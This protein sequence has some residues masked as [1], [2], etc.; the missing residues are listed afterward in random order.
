MTDS[1]LDPALTARFDVASKVEPPMDD[2]TPI[3][4]IALDVGG[5]KCAG[6]V[7]AVERQ[8]DVTGVVSASV[9]LVT[10]MA[11]VQYRSGSLDPQTLVQ[12][13]TEAGFP[14]QIRTT[15]ALSIEEI[16]ATEERQY[17]AA[18]DRRQQLVTA[19]VL[20]VL[21][22]IG[23]AEMLGLPSL[24]I[25]S[26]IWFHYGLATLSLLFPGR[27]IL[28]DGWRGLTHGTP[29]MNTL[30]GLGVTTA[31]VASSV[32][33]HVP[34]LGWDC[35]F[36]EP[37]MLLGFILLGRALER[38]ARDRAAS[39]LR[40]LVGLQPRTV[41]L[42]TKGDDLDQLDDR[43]VVDLPSN[44]V[45]VGDL[46]RVLPG[47]KL[48]VDGVV[49]AGTTAIDES[50]LTGEP[51]PIE[52]H[53]GDRVTTGT[54]N[55]SGAIVVR[56]Q[57]TGKDTTLAQIVE[58]VRDAQ[59]RK[60]PVQIF[61]DTVAGYFAYGIM[62]LAVVTLLFWSMAGVPLFG[63]HILHAQEW[64]MFGHAHRA[65]PH[66]GSPLLLAIKLM[67]DVLVIACP[68]AL[69]L[70]TPTAILVG[71]GLGAS[72]GLLIRGGDALERVHQLQTI[73]FDKTGTLTIGRPTVTDCATIATVSETE[74]IQLAASIEQGTSHPLA[75]ALV[76]AAKAKSI[77]LLPATDCKTEAG[78]GVTALVENRTI[79]VGNRPWLEACQITI[80]D[81]L[82]D[83][84]DTFAQAG[85]TVIFVAADGQAIATI[86][87]A[88]ELRPETAS[89]IRALQK[90]GLRVMMLTGDRRAAA[91]AIAQQ[92]GLAPENVIADVRPTEKSE[93][94]MRLQQSGQPS[95]QRVAMVGDGINDAPA[96][97]QADVGISLHGGT[98]VA[99]ETAQIVLMRSD[100]NDIVAAIRLSRATFNKIRQNIGWAFGYNAIGI[101]I[102]AGVLLPNFGIILNPAFAA[103]AMA[104]SS[105]SVVTNSL[106]LR[107]ALG[108]R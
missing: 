52:K 64:P 59:T 3:E 60:A 50:M 87:I 98:D 35:F 48:P 84:A 58:L 44:Q 57:R 100:L 91:D 40:A 49:M 13:L 23:H 55:Q 17:Q 32:A 53:H 82:T 107:R 16:E 27:P 95:K 93:A 10:E 51:L 14:S 65:M 25:F 89:A 105:I 1:Y 45:R 71:T 104:L 68:C 42:V 99:I 4:T 90:L 5:M 24:P 83:R 97:A 94:I 108:R 19:I 2:Q 81:E 56:A 78:A 63:D 47:E 102:A 11:A 18:H 7:K 96:L 61:A 66:H 9:N 20:I 85:K 86:A 88:D 103:V 106:L 38:H 62:A 33:M 69:G 28:L 74:A 46:L 54:L 37:V 67:I 8:L 12:R 72:R 41:H 31:Y 34:S 26:N 29:N 77:T 6:C 22:T 21:S 79:V 75:T 43:S 76:N 92:I 36:E 73:V 101:P 70:A 30:I 80:P 15:E 39:S